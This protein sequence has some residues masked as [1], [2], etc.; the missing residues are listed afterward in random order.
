MYRYDIIRVT[1]EFFNNAHFYHAKLQYIMK[2]NCNLGMN[3]FITDL[4]NQGKSLHGYLSELF[5]YIV[6]FPYSKFQI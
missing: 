1:Q 6:D 2:S 4:L 5:K 3:T